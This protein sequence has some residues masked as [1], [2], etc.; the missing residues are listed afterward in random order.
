MTCNSC[1]SHSFGKKRKV[2]PEAKLA[3]KLMYSEGITLG[4]AWKR[5]KSGKGSKKRG[6][7]KRGSK[8]RGSK[9]RG[10]KRK[11]RRSAKR[12]FG[13]RKTSKL[14]RAKNSLKLNRKK[15]NKRRKSRRGSKRMSRKFGM[16][17]GPGYA[18]QTS[19]T[20][21]Y[22]PY[23]GNNSEPFVNP[24]NWW[25]PYTGGQMQSPKMLMKSPN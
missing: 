12:S 25:F 13:R 9:R 17:R 18:G 10:S 3:M 14:S 24:S 8:K 21:A 6:S 16:V 7:K 11:A 22:A 1:N 15:M 23:F 4:E 19:Y 20:N 5:V 2:N